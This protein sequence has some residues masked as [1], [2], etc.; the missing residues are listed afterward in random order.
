MLKF[1]FS[2]S[3]IAFFLAGIVGVNYDTHFCCGELIKSEL[4][5]T[6]ETLSCGMGMNKALSKKYSDEE[7]ISALCCENH[8]LTFEIDNDFSKY[9]K[10]IQ[11]LPQMDIVPMD[12]ERVTTQMCNQPK[13]E[14]L[15]YSPPPLDRD[16]ILL[17]QS[18]LI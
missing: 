6:P 18:F 1:V 16:I 3:L 13:Y 8:R 10:H 12:V 7:T 11:F 4:S 2:I 17:V 14:D 9:S 5:I 15:G